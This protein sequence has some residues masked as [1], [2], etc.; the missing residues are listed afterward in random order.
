MLFGAVVSACLAM[1]VLRHWAL[2]S[3]IGLVL[4]VLVSLGCLYCLLTALIVGLGEAIGGN[5]WRFRLRALLWMIVN[6]AALV[7]LAVLVVQFIRG[8]KSPLEG[9]VG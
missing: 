2:R 1:Y 9:V 7:T 5:G 8:C 6:L 4:Y 3:A